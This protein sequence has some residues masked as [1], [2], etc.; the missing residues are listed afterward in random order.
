VIDLYLI[1]VGIKSRQIF[2]LVYGG[3]VSS[4]KAMI[5]VSARTR[6]SPV[7]QSNFPLEKGFHLPLVQSNF[8][9]FRGYLKAF[10][11][12]KRIADDL[13]WS[14]EFWINKKYNK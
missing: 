6:V 1:A 14:G 10:D 8:P 9:R 3:R 2:A 4:L 5:I 7:V 12:G 11:S 13:F